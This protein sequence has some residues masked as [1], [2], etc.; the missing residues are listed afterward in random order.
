MLIPFTP[1]TELII[2]W[3]A[4]G[5]PLWGAQRTAVATLRKMKPCIPLLYKFGTTCAT[6]CDDIWEC[7]RLFLTA[8][9]AY[10]ARRAGFAAIGVRMVASAFLPLEER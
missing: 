4:R 5:C 9:G 7:A 6:A 3:A 1:P 8:H 2:L 10:K